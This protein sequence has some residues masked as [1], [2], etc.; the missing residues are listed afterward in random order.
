M[1]CF[2]ES[3]LIENVETEWSL[4]LANS[5]EKYGEVVAKLYWND[6]AEANLI[7]E[8]P[9]TRI[10]VDESKTFSGMVTPSDSD[11]KLLL[12]VED[13]SK[14]CLLVKMIEVDVKKLPELTVSRI[15]WVDNKDPTR[16]VMKLYHLVTVQWDMQRSLLIIKVI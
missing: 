7:H 13:S 9:Q 6:E 2:L 1:I 16:T 10:E 11:D 4:E 5:G 14:G 8:T 3:F 12:T 15:E